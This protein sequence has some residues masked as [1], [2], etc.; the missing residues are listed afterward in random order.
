M[1]SVQ[2]YSS[3]EHNPDSRHGNDGLQIVGD[4]TNKEVTS[5]RVGY[6][7]PVQYKD[8]D[9]Q[10]TAERKGGGAISLVWLVI[11]CLA[12]LMGGG[13]GGGIAAGVYSNRKNNNNLTSR[14]VS[15]PNL[16]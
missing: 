4:N 2:I 10:N 5:P 15:D 7:I 16:Y 14:Y 9:S 6:D 3:L 12:F 8:K 13:L 1:S 11:A